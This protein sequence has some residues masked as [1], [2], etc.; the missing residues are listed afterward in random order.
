MNNSAELKITI[1]WSS[2]IFDF[3]LSILVSYIIL[4]AVKN[5]FIAIPSALILFIAMNLLIIKREC[6]TATFKKDF[7]LIEYPA[8]FKNII[9]PYKD[10]M[11]IKNINWA[12]RDKPRMI[13]YYKKDGQE[14]NIKKDMIPKRGN[15][16]DNAIKLIIEKNPACKIIEKSGI[17]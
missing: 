7:I 9:I 3:I 2:V 14:N 13:I 6:I 17:N 4:A 12:R 5:M 8:L 16:G 15:L 10:I 11:V 1:S